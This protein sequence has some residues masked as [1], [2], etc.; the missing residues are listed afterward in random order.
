MVVY[1]RN[2]A[3]VLGGDIYM[4]VGLHVGAEGAAC[5]ADGQGVSRLAV[6]PCEEESVAHAERAGVGCEHGLAFQ[7]PYPSEAVYVALLVNGLRVKEIVLP[8]RVAAVGVVVQLEEPL[9]VQ[10]AVVLD[11]ECILQAVVGVEPRVRQSG[12]AQVGR[13]QVVYTITL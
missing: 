3:V 13:I 4:F 2:D 7:V 5:F 11:L 6:K 10:L 1:L 12:Y 9:R 8:R